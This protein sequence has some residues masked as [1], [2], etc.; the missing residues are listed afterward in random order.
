MQLNLQIKI[1]LIYAQMRNWV[2]RRWLYF[3]ATD[4]RGSSIDDT[5]AIDLLI[6]F[7]VRR[8]L[9]SLSNYD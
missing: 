5:R 6:L 3:N 1:L 4:K 2:R 8:S 7:F 9:Y